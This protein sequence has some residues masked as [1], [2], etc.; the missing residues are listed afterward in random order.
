M[1]FETITSLID[2]VLLSYSHKIKSVE[3]SI[4]GSGYILVR[5]KL[6]NGIRVQEYINNIDNIRSILEN[7]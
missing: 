6:I 2:S 7:G 5:L 4:G 1:N 3:F